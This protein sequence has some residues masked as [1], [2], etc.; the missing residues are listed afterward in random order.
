MFCWSFYLDYIS[1]RDYNK[2]VI[3]GLDGRNVFYTGCCKKWN[4][5]PSSAL[6]HMQL[7]GPRTEPSPCPGLAVVSEL[8]ICCLSPCGT[9]WGRT[10]VGYMSYSTLRTRGFF[11][12]FIS[13]GV[14]EPWC[15][16]LTPA[17]G[18]AAALCSLFGRGEKSQVWC[19]FTSDKG[20]IGVFRE[21]WRVKLR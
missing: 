7:Q 6:P 19:W 15:S 9:V 13:F 21:S 10:N 2:Y 16:A 17:A 3:L 5:R 4:V 1:Q 14:V 11:V 12:C 8:P 20:E 18:V